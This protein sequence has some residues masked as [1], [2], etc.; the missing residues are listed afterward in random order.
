M[1]GV[2]VCECLVCM[3]CVKLNVCLLNLFVEC[4]QKL[5]SSSV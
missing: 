1:G 4:P 5:C 2:N 3:F